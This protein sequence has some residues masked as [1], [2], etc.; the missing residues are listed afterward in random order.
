MSIRE[1][2][3]RERVAIAIYE[4]RVHSAFIHGWDAEPEALRERF[5][6]AA[7]RALQASGAVDLL[8]QAVSLIAQPTIPEHARK[9]WQAAVDE[10]LGDGTAA[11]GQ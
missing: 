4:A 8:E 6:K 1:R 11:G 10:L 7:D 3:E 5:L 9:R 2:S